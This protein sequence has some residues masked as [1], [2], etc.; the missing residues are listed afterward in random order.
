[1]SIDDPDPRTTEYTAFGPDDDRSLSEA[2]LDAVE[3]HQ[4]IDL[5]DA[6]FTLYDIVNP[7]A[8]ERLF[9]FNRHAAT[10]V[11][12]VVA[13]AHVSLRDVGNEIEIRV[14]DR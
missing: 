9:R 2:V 13:D 8:L 5:V 7:E 12:F 1:M 4:G 11:S 10:T 14:R 3:E 6:E